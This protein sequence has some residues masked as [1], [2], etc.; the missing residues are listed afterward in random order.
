MNIVQHETRKGRPKT[1]WNSVRRDCR[2]STTGRRGDECHSK[3]Y[4]TH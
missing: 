2:K 3:L 1:K 4:R